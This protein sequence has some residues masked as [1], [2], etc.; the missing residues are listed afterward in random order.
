MR[1]RARL[2]VHWQLEEDAKTV[3]S[4]AIDDGAYRDR[5]VQM[6]GE[7]NASLFLI[8]YRRTF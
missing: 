7:L 1:L 3:C 5:A 8:C 4:L 6:Y 2:R